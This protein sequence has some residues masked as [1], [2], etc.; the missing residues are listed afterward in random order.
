MA[1]YLFQCKNILFCYLSIFIYYLFCLFTSQNR[2][3]NL[4][5]KEICNCTIVRMQNFCC[6]LSYTKKKKSEKDRSKHKGTC[7]EQ[8]G[9]KSISSLHRSRE[10]IICLKDLPRGQVWIDISHNISETFIVHGI[11]A[12]S[13]NFDVSPYLANALHWCTR[14]TAVRHSPR[15]STGC[16][17][18]R[19]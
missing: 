4:I 19:K 10:A 9:G 14:D 5:F 15:D 13:L 12:V 8:K 2:L 11:A 17:L 3:T 16:K 1:T 18:A 7:R 6:L